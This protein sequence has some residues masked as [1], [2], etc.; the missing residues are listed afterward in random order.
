MKT[1]T[2]EH[3]SLKAAL[4][5]R[6]K[7]KDRGGVST[8]T[9]ENRVYTL[10]YEFPKKKPSKTTAKKPARKPRLYDVLSPD[11][12][13]IRKEGVPPFRSMKERGEYF[14]MWVAP[15]QRQ[16]YYLSP[17]YGKIPASLVL[18]LSCGWIEW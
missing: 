17:K 10:S 3:T 4:A 6:T 5:H 14:D 9:E 13:T 12:V 16:G 8:L 15:Y 11:G 18:A 2:K 1:Y 7:I